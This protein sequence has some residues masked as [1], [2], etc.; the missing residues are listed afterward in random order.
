MRR[1]QCQ[2][3]RVGF[4]LIE[5]LVVVAIIAL[6]ISILLPSLARARDEA[7][8]TVCKA[9]NNQLGMS[10]R[11][12][13]DTYKAYPAWDDGDN[14][15]AM[16][17]H[18]RVLSTWIDVLHATRF[19][20]DLSLGECPKDMKPDPL[21][22]SRGSEWNFRRPDGQYGMDYSY[23]ISVP[24]ATMGWKVP[25]TKYRIDAHQSSVVLA[26]DGAWTWM[27]GFGAPGVSRNIATYL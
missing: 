17:F 18:N 23:G 7:K 9:R 22:A 3:G 13:F 21:A 16:D 10:L 11:Y 5:V 1:H 14:T 20:P 25:N 4:T 8:D 27:H 2:K 19:L 12:C 26:G 15:Q 24:A 6:L